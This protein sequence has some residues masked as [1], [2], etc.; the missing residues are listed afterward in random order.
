MTEYASNSE[1][2]VAYGNPIV[3]ALIEKHG[4]VT[5]MRTYLD[6]N[7]M[8]EDP[9]FDT[10]AEGG[11]VAREVLLRAPPQQMSTDLFVLMAL[12]TILILRRRS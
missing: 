9:D 11:D 10:D 5:R 6:P 1:A 12:A 3:E 2:L 7:E 4:Y 8:T